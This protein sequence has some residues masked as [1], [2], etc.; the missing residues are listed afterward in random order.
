M[1]AGVTCDLYKST[2]DKWG[3]PQLDGT[4]RGSRTDCEWCTLGNGDDRGGATWRRAEDRPAGA[5]SV[6]KRRFGS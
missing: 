6:D 5:V 3:R 1:S 2:F 4:A